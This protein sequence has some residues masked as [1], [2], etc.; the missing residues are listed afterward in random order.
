MLFFFFPR[1]ALRGIACWKRNTT[2]EFLHLAYHR[3]GSSRS[4]WDF[5]LRFDD[6]DVQQGV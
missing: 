5:D 1:T 3:H 4:R 2:Y 6:V